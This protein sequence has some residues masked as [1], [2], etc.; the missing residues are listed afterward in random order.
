MRNAMVA[1]RVV[2]KNVRSVANTFGYALCADRTCVVALASA[3]IAHRFPMFS[4]KF[5]QAP[6]IEVG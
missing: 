6:V 4:C 1:W 3:G 5:F 2:L